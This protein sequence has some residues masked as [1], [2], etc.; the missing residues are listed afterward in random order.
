MID[1]VF[2]ECSMYVLWDQGSEKPLD[3]AL[4]GKA[5]AKL[6]HLDWALF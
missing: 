3:T 2:S 1:Q 6:E 5:H 4:L